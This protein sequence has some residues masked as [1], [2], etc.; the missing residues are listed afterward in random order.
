MSPTGLSATAMAFAAGVMAHSGAITAL[1]NPL[2]N[3]YKRLATG[4]EAP[5]YV[6]WAQRNR[7]PMIRVPDASVEGTRLE[8]RSPDPTCNP[9]L[10]FAAMQAAGLDG[11][12]NNLTPPP[13]AESNLYELTYEQR[14]AMGIESLPLD[15]GA[16]LDA[17]EADGLI[18][19][20]LGAHATANYLKAKRLEWA[21]YNREVHAWEL[22]RYLARY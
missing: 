5:V 18:C 15:L 21:E 9:Y 14:A 17:L 1:A 20:T 7:S 8:L 10:A 13:M 4:F 12:R 16:A 11:M 19:D 22:D 3:S 6:S 2:V